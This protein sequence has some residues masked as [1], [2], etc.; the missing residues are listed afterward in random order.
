MNLVIAELVT[1]QRGISRA[2]LLAPV[3]FAAHVAEEAPGFVQWF[4]SLARAGITPS[5][6]FSVNA[7]GFT[8]TII[9]AGM[10]AATRERGAATLMLAWLGGIMFANAIFHLVATVVHAKY[11]PG[12]ITASIL[13]LPY[14][15]W[16]FSVAV[17]RLHVPPL[18]AIGAA[19]LGAVPM[20]AHG[21]LIVF[22]GER[23]F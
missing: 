19:L 22:R 10:L 5:L 11:C 21:Y 8:I 7:V 9:V 2:A 17:R 23:L 4:N 13:Y 18:I 6:F 12:V 16:F 14:F 3:I 1:N 20:A 15:A